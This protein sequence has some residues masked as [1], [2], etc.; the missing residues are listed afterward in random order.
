MSKK[1]LFF[2]ANSFFQNEIGVK[3]SKE[4]K[5]SLMA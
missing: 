5:K 1:G 4:V 3:E 2:G